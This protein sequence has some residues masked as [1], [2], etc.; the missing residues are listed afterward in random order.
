MPESC[1]AT[2]SRSQN[3]KDIDHLEKHRAHKGPATKGL[4]GVGANFPN[5]STG[6][7]DNWIWGVGSNVQCLYVGGAQF[8]TGMCGANF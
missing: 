3:S 6:V 4:Y 8:H 7:K 5:A 2:N 1:V